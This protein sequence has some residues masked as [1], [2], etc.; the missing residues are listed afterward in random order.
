M[1]VVEAAVL[2]LV[3]IVLG[4]LTGLGVGAILLALTGGLTPG[5]GLPWA[6]I[7]VA[8]V[9]GIAGSVIAAYYPS[10]L[11]SGVSIVQALTFE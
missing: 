2:G 10:R 7:G 1:V 11:A 3:G 6:P 5:L 8:A 9:I 4:A